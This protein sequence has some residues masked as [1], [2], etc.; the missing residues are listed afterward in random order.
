MRRWQR[1]TP[2]TSA[3]QRAVRSC[4]ASAACSGFTTWD[5]T[6]HSLSTFQVASMSNLCHP[7]SGRPAHQLLRHLATAVRSGS[8]QL[9]RA[10]FRSSVLDT[11]SL[12]GGLAI[13]FLVVAYIL[14]VS[15]MCWPPYSS[16]L[17]SV[18]HL[19]AWTSTL[20][21]AGPAFMVLQSRYV[22]MRAE[23]DSLLC[24]HWQSHGAGGGHRLECLPVCGAPCWA[25]AQRRLGAA[26][27]GFCRMIDEMQRCIVRTHTICSA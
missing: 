23:A 20:I 2:A 12:Y 1:W 27:V 7:A 4:A 16:L 5:F 18:V 6:R 10:L 26:Q 19:T 8:R 14:Q 25:A 21:T 17:Q 3:W 22:R 11:L 15:C 24:A 13:F 9:L